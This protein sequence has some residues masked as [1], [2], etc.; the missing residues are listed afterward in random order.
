MTKDTSC[1]HSCSFCVRVRWL[2]PA[3]LC[4]LQRRTENAFF[5]ILR[6][7]C[8]AR[9]APRQHYLCNARPGFT[10][11]DMD[12]VDPV[13]S[14]KTSRFISYI[15]KLF[16][17]VAASGPTA[18]EQILGSFTRLSAL[19]TVAASDTWFCR[20]S[21]VPCLLIRRT[22]CS[23]RRSLASAHGARLTARSCSRSNSIPRTR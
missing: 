4:W 9:E 6:R 3:W 15:R 16:T 8:L 22:S 21:N 5:I 12:S 1:G 23:P 11:Y 2:S 13:V 20:R 7:K 19:S 10:R 17:G 14:L 18:D